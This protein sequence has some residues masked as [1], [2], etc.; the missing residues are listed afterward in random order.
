M[1]AILTYIIQV[2]ILLV[3]IY[4]GYFLLLKGLTF[5]P[6]NRVYFIL[7]GIFALL[8][9]FMNIPAL[10]KTH[11]EPI[12]EVVAYIPG[13]L[14]TE[15]TIEKGMDIQQVTLAL[16]ALG[17][18]VLF[19]KLAVQ[20]F[21][22]MRIHRHS[23]EASWRTYVYRN[24]LFPI[25][26]FSF[27]NRIYVN[28][29]QHEESELYDIFEHEQIHVKGLH[30]LDII[31][32]EAILILCWYNPV[33]WLLR[34]AVRQNLEFLTDQYV[35]NQG[36][37][38]QT[39]QYSLLHV[40]KQGATVGVG[41]QFNFKLL[42]KRITMMNKKRSSALELS[43][44]AFL[45]PVLIFVAAA[46]T[47]TKADEKISEVVLLAKQTEVKDL[48]RVLQQKDTVKII[49]VTEKDTVKG[50]FIGLAVQD[51]GTVVK[52][53]TE[54]GVTDTTAKK[55][56]NVFIFRT[57]GNVLEKGKP[58][59]VVDGKLMDPMFEIN[60]IDAN[61]I[62]EISIIKGEA[63]TNIYGPEAKNGVIYITTKGEGKNNE[64]APT[65]SYRFTKEGDT[66]SGTATILGTSMQKHTNDSINKRNASD[67]KMSIRI[68]PGGNGPKPLM[69]IDGVVQEDFDAAAKTLIPENI[70]SVTVLK[71]KQSTMTYG[72]KG[73]NGILIVTTKE[74][75]R[76]KAAKAD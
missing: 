14:Q 62:K 18:M 44:Y 26:P 72:A 12:G 56:Q 3:F 22:L 65:Q 76:V 43:K 59:A 70:A 30:T 51:E 17:A 45:L 28:A 21:S 48:Q 68:G 9:P 53:A 54:A 61:T 63:S 5:H 74:G 35:L 69:V 31:L 6:L 49:A 29:K 16:F 11:M 66:K 73:E 15:K 37:D 27:F 46:F 41:N 64:V 13:M 67:P 39:Y 25:A 19:L 10:F 7:G 20:L 4:L 50:K 34:K 71:D 38:R 32:F 40:S 55:T 57:N 23:I 1:E 58:L 2:N 52:K 42:K 36:V 75:E 24:V 33:V 47:V 8:Y 60:E